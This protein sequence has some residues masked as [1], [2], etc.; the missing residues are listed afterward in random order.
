[1]LS[2]R[3]HAFSADDFDVGHSGTF[4]HEIH[5]TGNEPCYTPQF[6]L[7]DEHLSF[8]KNSVMGWLLKQESS[9]AHV[10]YITRRFSAS[11]K[12]PWARTGVLS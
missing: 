10:P 4:K 12:R 3:K 11:T 7:S 1:M 6:R 9:N 8:L 2:A 5:F